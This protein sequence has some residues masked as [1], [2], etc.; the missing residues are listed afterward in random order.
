MN[1]FVEKYILTSG[2]LA[3]TAVW[4]G[5]WVGHIKKPFPL[6]VAP[7]QLYSNSQDAISSRLIKML[8]LAKIRLHWRLWNQSP[9]L[10]S[11]ACFPMDYV[12]VKSKLQ[13]PPGHLTPFPAREGGNLFTTHRGRGIWLLASI[14]CCESPWFHV[15]FRGLRRQT[16]M[17]SKEKI[18]YLWRIGWKP[19]AYTSCAPCLK[20]FKNDLLL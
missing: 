19:K 5:K 10:V 4:L 14:S 8:S 17:N 11:R 13:H 12:L 15:C 9:T 18:A 1:V 3:F 2:V 6:P 16:F 7:L 20:V